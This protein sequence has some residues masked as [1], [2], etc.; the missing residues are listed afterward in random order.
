MSTSSESLSP[1][2]AAEPSCF[3]KRFTEEWMFRATLWNSLRAWAAAQRSSWL[4][5]PRV[6]QADA[7]ELRI[8][9]EFLPGWFP[10]H[11]V[12]RHRTFAGLSGAELVG[13]FWMLGAA[14]EEFHRRTHRIHGDFDFDNILVKRGADRV[15]FVDFTPPEYSAFR[16]YNQASPY[17]DIA[18]LVIFVRAK[19]PP[20][21]IYLAFRPQLRK[22]AR[23][24]VEG[25]F[26][27]APAEF[28]RCMLEHHMNELLQNTYLGRSFS[29]RYLRRSRLFRTDDLTPEP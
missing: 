4:R 2:P 16:R 9:Y 6:L 10:L 19:Y 7:R 3:S 13:L 17:R 11:T 29:A 25:Y 18:S 20:Q 27:N 26:R 14:L 5:V 28:D 23:S 22:L 24:F 15:V 21:L 8:D 12:L 1:S